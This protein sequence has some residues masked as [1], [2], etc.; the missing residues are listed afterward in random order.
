MNR[1]FVKLFL[2]LALGISFLSAVADRFGIWGDAW[3]N[4]DNFI[5]YTQTLLPWLSD[6]LAKISGWAATLAEVVFGIALIIGYK[7]KWMAIGSGILLFL[8]ALAMWQSL[9]LKAPLNYS[10]FSASAAAFALACMKEKFLEI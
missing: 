4:M 7:V 10:V 2:R 1:G 3:G 5:V 8:F 9:G 6:P